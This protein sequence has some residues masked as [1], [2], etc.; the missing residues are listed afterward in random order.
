[1]KRRIPFFILSFIILFSQNLSATIRLLTFHCNHAEFLEYQ[2]IGLEKFLSDE[3]ELIVINDG[4]NQ[5][6]QDAIKTVCER[7]GAMNVSYEQS[8][9]KIDPL[10]E[11]VQAALSTPLGNDYFRFPFK[12]GYPDIQK[13]YENVSVRH[14]HLIQYALDHYGYDNDDIVV[15]MDGDLIAIQPVS[16]RSLLA[17]VPIVGIDSEFRDKHYLWVPF[18][19]FDPKRLPNLR[20]LKF[21]IDLI[22]GV[23]CD[24]GS[25]SYHY[26]KNNPE[27]NYRFYPRCHDSD[28]FPYDAAAF[29]KFGLKSMANTSIS[30]PTRM[31]YYVDYRFIHF[32]GGSG[33]HPLRKFFD[34]ADLMECILEQTVP[35]ITQ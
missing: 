25:H 11:Q 33:L 17:E 26:L 35:V 2:C 12:D 16:I 27:V 28:F 14:C 4:V 23:V 9:H 22:D 5:K 21:H 8:W 3:Y 32:C 10:N 24:T 34:I 18:I 29:S 31:E 7:Y 13:I 1:M 6:E 19:A 30:W 20:D 15:I